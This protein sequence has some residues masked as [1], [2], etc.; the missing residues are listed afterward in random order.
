MQ[1][2]FVHRLYWDYVYTRPRQKNKITSGSPRDFH[3]RADAALK[4]FEKCATDKSVEQ[5]VMEDF[6]VKP[7]TKLPVSVVKTLSIHSP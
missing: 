4:Q 6:M 5:C 3:A 1:A 7:T 2:L